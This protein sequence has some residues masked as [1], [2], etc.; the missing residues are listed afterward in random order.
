[1]D[2]T[3][4][5]NLQ[6]PCNNPPPLV[7]QPYGSLRSLGSWW[8]PPNPRQNRG[9]AQESQQ[10]SGSSGQETQGH[11]T[12]FGLDENEP[13]A[14]MR[15]SMRS[16]AAQ[17]VHRVLVLFERHRL[18]LTQH[19]ICGF[20][21]LSSPHAGAC[22]AQ[23]AAAGII[24]SEP[25]ARGRLWHLCGA[26]GENKHRSSPAGVK[27]P[28]LNLLIAPMKV[29]QMAKHPKTKPAPAEKGRP[30]RPRSSPL[31]P[32][33]EA[34]A[35]RQRHRESKRNGRHGPSRNLAATGMA[36]CSN[37]ARRNASGCGAG[38][39]PFAHGTLGEKARATALRSD[40]ANQTIT[41]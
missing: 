12:R 16:P 19:E 7:S 15:A 31:D 8:P 5:G 27:L 2:F 22:L 28:D 38:S 4:R 9:S 20:T 30:G 14:I 24:S 13:G 35:R 41:C 6:S 26:A 3:N 36:R 29:T 34:L 40:P 21:S 11:W 17:D 32:V 23:L 33:E 18:G 37:C 39:F 1:M 25:Y 10:S